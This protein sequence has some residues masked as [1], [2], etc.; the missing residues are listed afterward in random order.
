MLHKGN[1]SNSLEFDAKLIAHYDQ[2]GPRYTSYPTAAQFTDH[3][4]QTDYR[5]WAKSKQSGISP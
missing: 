5:R 1:M 2:S 3:F 4:N